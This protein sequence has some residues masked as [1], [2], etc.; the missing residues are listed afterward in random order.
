MGVAADADAT[1]TPSG[2]GWSPPP[3]VPPLKG[4]GG[5]GTGK[6]A[7]TAQLAGTN[8]L[9]IPSC[10]IRYISPALSWPKDVIGPI[11]PNTSA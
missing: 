6:I 7:A 3:S 2:W 9:T 11:A 10:V 1:A 5:D 4:E 8:F